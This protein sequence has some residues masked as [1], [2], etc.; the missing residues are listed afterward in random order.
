MALL[1]LGAGGYFGYRQFFAPTVTE[2]VASKLNFDASVTDAEKQQI[3]QAFADQGIILN[4]D[5]NVS[6]NETTEPASGLILSAQVPVV[7]FNSAKQLITLEQLKSKSGDFE[8]IS[9]SELSTDKKLLSVGK[10]YYLDSF[11]RGAIFREAV[12]SGDNQVATDNLVTKLAELPTKESTLKFNQTGVTALTREMM[13]QI[14]TGGDSKFFSK[15]IGKF[16]ADA[17]VTHVS[18]EVS[19]KNGCGYSHTS[20]C[21]PYN[22]LDAL[23]DSGV[24]VVEITGN[25]NNDTGNQYNT[26]SIKLYHDLGWGTFGGGLNLAEAKKPW[27]T[28]QKGTK[29]ALLGYNY[30]DAGPPAGG[31]VATATTAGAN[32]FDFDYG[33]I[34][35]DIAKV[36]EQG[37]VAVVDIQF[38]E[39]YAYPDGYVEFPECDAPIG[40]QTETFRKLIDIGADIVVGSSAHQPQTYELYKGKPI[41]Y[42]LGNLYFDQTYWPGTERGLVLTHY[43]IGGKLVQTKI[44]PTVYN[45]DYQT[46]IMGNDKAEWLLNRLVK[47][48]P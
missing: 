32:P 39:C 20:F 30:P 11:N 29:L 45:K 14:G 42:G 23:K 44:T 2:Q 7:D 6:V 19:F 31:A 26:D 35:A 8:L 27:L 1:L 28:D 3:T 21:S 12:F 40:K 24:D 36:H 17:D 5:L 33:D 9:A 22:M 41:Y 34:E 38:W 18:N 15:Y 46:Q 48:Q 47:A 16:L 37:Y 25:H 10:D 13:H 43:F 4:S